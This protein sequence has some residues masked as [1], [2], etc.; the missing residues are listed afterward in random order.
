MPCKEGVKKT[1]SRGEYAHYFI[2][3]F[4][5]CCCVLAAD[6]RSSINSMTIFIARLIYLINIEPAPGFSIATQLLSTGFTPGA[7]HI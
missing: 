6:A 4:L 3:P 7:T 2:C 1:L 5:P